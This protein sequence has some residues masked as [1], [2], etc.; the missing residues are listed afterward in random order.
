MVAS[1]NETFHLSFFNLFVYEHAHSAERRLTK[2]DKTECSKQ[3][4]KLVES[5][6]TDTFC[7]CIEDRTIGFRHIKSSRDFDRTSDSS[8]VLQTSPAW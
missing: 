2:T 4:L 6:V 3:A 5:Q 1:G 7:K 8:S